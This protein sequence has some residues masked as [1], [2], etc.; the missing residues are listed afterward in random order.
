M[1]GSVCEHLTNTTLT[2]CTLLLGLLYFSKKLRKWKVRGLVQRHVAGKLA[3][4]ESEPRSAT[5]KAHNSTH[6]ASWYPGTED[7]VAP[8]R[9]EF[10]ESHACDPQ[11][12]MLP[13]ITSTGSTPH[14]APIWPFASNNYSLNAYHARH[15]SM[16]LAGV[17]EANRLA[18]HIPSYHTDFC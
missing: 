7:Q 4:Q 5:C 15:P 6:W 11:P 12:S 2:I 1:F 8:P 16:R 9:T 13:T 18:C 17:S 10:Q 14:I 3:E